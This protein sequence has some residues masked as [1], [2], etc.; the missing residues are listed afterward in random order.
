MAAPTARDKCASS[1]LIGT[2]CHRK[3]NVF[4]LPLSINFVGFYWIDWYSERWED[5]KLQ[6][7][8]VPFSSITAA[9]YCGKSYKA[10]LD[11]YLFATFFYRSTQINS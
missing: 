2:T 5:N 8:D 11:F 6:Q 10:L 9:K 1:C 4:S 3:N 7:R